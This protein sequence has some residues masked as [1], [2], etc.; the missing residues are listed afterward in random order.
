MLGSRYPVLKLEEVLL[1]LSISAALNPTAQL[2]MEQLPRLRGC[3]AH[4]SDIITQADANTFLKLGVN[5]TCEPQ[6]PTKDLYFK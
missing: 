3:D 4:C 2:A 5:V 1:A 6:Y